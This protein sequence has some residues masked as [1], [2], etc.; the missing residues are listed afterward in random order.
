M[1]VTNHSSIAIPVKADT[2]DLA[3]EKEMCS[4]AIF[5]KAFV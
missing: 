2:T 4:L 5:D 3:T 1:F